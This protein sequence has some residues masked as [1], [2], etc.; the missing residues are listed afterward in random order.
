MCALPDFFLSDLFPAAITSKRFLTHS[1]TANAPVKSPNLPTQP[2]P[3]KLA[4]DVS[5]DGT[6]SF[7]KI[8][9]TF[10]KTRQY[11]YIT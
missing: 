10:M 6:K 3:E 11:M 2:V 9:L 4:A 8:V 1:Q 7:D 5:T